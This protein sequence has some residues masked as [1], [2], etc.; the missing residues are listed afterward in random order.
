MDRTRQFAVSV[1]VSAATA[2]GGGSRPVPVRTIAMNSELSATLAAGDPQLADHGSYHNYSFTST[3][4]QNVQIDVLSSE[5]DAFA[6]LHDARGTM[7]ASANDGGEGNNARITFVL[8]EDG[9]YRIAA[10]ANRP[11]EVGNYR[12]RLTTLGGVRMIALG[13]TATGQLQPSDQRL[14]DNFLYHSYQFNA[15]AGQAVTIDAGAS[16]FDPYLMILDAGSTRIA[17]DDDSGEG[18]NPRLTFTFPYEGT[19]RILVGTYTANRGG[20]YSLSVR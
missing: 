19:F 6:I 4:G 2:C 11:G 5:F 20:A 13:R 10:T 14:P 16:D 12:I 9:T 18:R 8:R 17:S 7:L 15:R 3:A 1:L